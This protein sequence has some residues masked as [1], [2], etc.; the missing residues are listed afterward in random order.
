[1]NKSKKIAVA[2]VSMVLAGTIAGSLAACGK[3]DSAE[4][5]QRSSEIPF[6]RF[7]ATSD[8]IDQVTVGGLKLS[9]FKNNTK[10]VAYPAGT[11][12][13]VN[14]IDSNNKDRQISYDSGQIATI[15]NAVDNYT[16][17]VGSLKPAWWQLGQDL[18]IKFV[19]KAVPDRSGKEL[20]EAVAQGELANYNLINSSVTAINTNKGELLNLA[21]FLEYMPNFQNFLNEY[22]IVKWSLQMDENGGMY[23][24]PY[25]DGNDDIEKYEMVQRDWVKVILDGTLDGG[26]AISYLEQYRAKV[27]AAASSI[28]ADSL[29][30]AWMG[31]TAA[32]NW[33]VDTTNPADTTKTVKLSVSYGDVITALKDSNSALYKAIV[34]AGVSAPQSESGNIVDIQNQIITAT[35]GAVKGDKLANVLREYIKVAYKLNGSAYTTLSDVFLSASAGWDADL[36]VAMFRCV[37]TNFK[38]FNGLA[39]AAVSEV[40][41]LAGRQATPQRENDI[42]ALAG[43]LYGV[44]GME[45]RLDYLYVDNA[46]NLQDAR[47]EQESYEA[48]ARFNKLAKEGLLYN[49]VNTAAKDVTKKYS[50]GSPISFMLHDYVQTQTKDGFTNESF[51][52]APILTPV[53]RW[54]VDGNDAN[55]KETVM[56]F[57]ESWRSVKNSGVAIPKKSVSD[58]NTLAAVISF[59]DYLFSNDGQIIGSYGPM[60]TKGNTAE[61]DGYW[62]GNN[63]VSVL[64]ADGTVKSEYANKVETKDGAQYFLKKANRSEGF[65]YKNVLYTGMKYKDKQ[66]PIMTDNNMNFYLGQEVNNVK[67]STENTIGYKK[68]HVGNYTDYARGVVGAALPIGNKDQGFEYQCTASCG[69]DG[70]AIVNTA[71]QNGSIKHLTQEINSSAWWYTVVPT[72][73]PLEEVQSTAIGAQSYFEG[74][75]TTASYFNATSGKTVSNVY[76]DLAFWGYGTYK[77]GTCHNTT[78][79]YDMKASAAELV[80]TISAHAG[81]A[82]KNRV[83]WYSAAWNSLKTKN[84]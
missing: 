57:T 2:A 74:D 75:N 44:R 38:A 28:P 64:N 9:V 1:M 56:R 13:N 19:D 30:E 22:E 73:L 14:I 37:V 16:Y 42:I 32:D 48:A 60:S 67:M 52:F 50:P 66:I 20:T 18:G 78:G 15:W 80:A 72:V 10:K 51:D 25:F 68:N 34:A 49:K 79:S 83:N 58:P 35:N 8:Q 6:T 4:F 41:A 53:S 63:G 77:I 43:E 21:D 23:Y 24:I 84:A 45:S 39:D 54:D 36:M 65:M 46:G 29:A 61:A 59:V 27:D 40:Y 81:G 82:L 3:K 17:V 76:I 11:T 71:I 33:E 12:L 70:A 31:K 26:K 62:Y 7:N 55:G 47:L 5:S 69:L